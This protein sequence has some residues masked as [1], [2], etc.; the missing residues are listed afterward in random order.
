MRAGASIFARVL[1]AGR[2]VLVSIVH[3]R[4]ARRTVC[5]CDYGGEEGRQ[6]QEEGCQEENREEGRQEEEGGQE[7]AHEE[8]PEGQEADQQARCPLARLVREVG[9]EQGW[10]REGG[11]HEEQAWQDRLQEGERARGEEQVDRCCDEGPQG[12]FYTEVNTIFNT[13]KYKVFK[14]KFE[15]VGKK[16]F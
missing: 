3:R 8:A 2:V 1:W 5:A 15:N 4:V 7:E 13:C 14:S 12:P 9:Q 16:R 11:A 10:S 6:G